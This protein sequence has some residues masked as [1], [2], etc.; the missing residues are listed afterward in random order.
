M[1]PDAPFRLSNPGD[2]PAPTEWLFGGGRT[3][4][5]I[6]A[7]DWSATPL[8]PRHAWP[9][10][11]RTVVNLTVSSGIPIAT[12]WGSDPI[13]IYNDAYAVIAGHRHPGAMGRSMREV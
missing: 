13:F 10:D 12:L 5:L 8:G 6:R 1:N 3:G 11:L 2:E 9:Q 7:M 4:D